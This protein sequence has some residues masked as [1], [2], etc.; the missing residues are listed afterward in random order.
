VA[1]HGRLNALGTAVNLAAR[2]QT[3]A[4]PGEIVCSESINAEVRGFAW[5]EPLG[6][7]VIKGLGAPQALFRLVALQQA[8]SNL[9]G[10]MARGGSDYVGRESLR[11]QLAAW[12]RRAP[13]DPAVLVVTGPPGIGKSRLVHHVLT[14][15]RADAVPVIVNCSPADAT[16]PLQPVLRLLQ[17]AAKTDGARLDSDVAAWLDALLGPDEKALP[18]L[19]DLLRPDGSQH[20]ADAPSGAGAAAVELRRQILHAVSRLTARPGLRL[21]IEDAHWLDP[22]SRETLAEVFGATS[23]AGQRLLLTSRQPTPLPLAPG[24]GATLNVPPL[25]RDETLALCARL[26]PEAPPEIRDRAAGIILVQ[27]EGNP[28]FTEELTPHFASMHDIDALQAGSAGDIGLIQGL[29]FSRFDAL[30]TAEKSALKQAA[31]IGRE[32]RP[33]YLGPLASGGPGAAEILH[34]AADHGL[35]D[36]DDTGTWRFAHVLIQ[37]SIANSIPGGEATGLHRT[38]AKVLIAEGADPTGARSARVARHLELAGM[39]ARAAP[40]H[41]AAAVSAWRVYALDDCLDHLMAAAVQLDA[42]ENRSNGDLASAVVMRL[43]R[44]LDVAGNWTELAGSPTAI[45]PGSLPFPIRVPPS[46]C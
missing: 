9:P 10:R 22:L 17:A 3:L 38:A 42:D 26:L 36:R 25:T 21:I 14:G 32:I 40:H 24:R 11:G 20:P 2:L 37:G 23:E 7:H 45:W 29:V 28:L 30:G 4:A 39:P 27:S 43:C 8:P 19:L 13:A 31:I 15:L 41:L 18:A 12:L 1:D 35:F 46:W 6:S 34:L 5:T 33:A 16:A 44:V